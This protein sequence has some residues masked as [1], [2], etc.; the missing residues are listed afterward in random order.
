MIRIIGAFQPL[1]LGEVSKIYS[2][3]RMSDMA[4]RVNAGLIGAGRI[5]RVPA[6]VPAYRL[7]GANLMAV[8]DVFLEAAQK[9]AADF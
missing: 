2:M 5:G 6:E 1:N 7:P 9:C 4:D 3:E 8:S